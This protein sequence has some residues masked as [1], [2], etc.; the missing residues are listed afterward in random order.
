MGMMLW[1]ILL[2]IIIY[3]MIGAFIATL[4]TDRYDEPQVW[5][6]ILWPLLVAAYLLLLIVSLP[7][8][9][10]EYVRDK[11]KRR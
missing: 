7:V 4:L 5:I 10:G 11:H 1:L 6:I 2:I 9:L 3:L 8:K